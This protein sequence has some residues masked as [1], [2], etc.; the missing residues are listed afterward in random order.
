MAILVRRCFGFSEPSAGG[1]ESLLSPLALGSIGISSSGSS[2][3]GFIHSD[4][5]PVVADEESRLPRVMVR[6]DSLRRAGN[7]GDDDE[8]TGLE[9]ERF[10]MFQKDLGLRNNACDR[11]DG[12][13]IV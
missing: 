4:E 5:P 1:S 3:E 12:R 7:E 11:I 13:I 2:G 9:W 10:G 6:D 8:R